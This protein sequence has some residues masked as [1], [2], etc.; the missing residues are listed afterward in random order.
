VILALLDEAQRSGARLGPACET[1]GINKRTVERWRGQGV[2]DDRR[3]GPTSAPPNKLTQQE[4][5]QIVTT[6]NSPEYRDLSPN[7]IVPLLADKGHYLSSESSFYRILREEDLQHHRE[8]SRPAV[9]TRPSAKVATG[10][11]QVWSWDITYLPSPVRGQFFYL[12][13]VMDVWSRK[14][15]GWEVHPIEDMALS[16][17]MIRRLCEENDITPDQLKLH[18]DNGGP[19]KGATMLAT[20]QKLGVATSF[21]R[22]RV[23]DDNP[24][25]EALFRTLKYRP[26]YPKRPFESIEEAIAWVAGFV[27]WYNEEHLHSEISFVTP[28][29]RHAGRDAEILKNR[30]EVYEQARK[31]N[32]SRW[33]GKTRN[34]TA[35]IKVVLNGNLQQPMDAAA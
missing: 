13:L 3:E 22:P 18:A 9:H 34:W 35:P 24:Y 14:I 31:K 16:S 27:R 29:D 21:S 26:E 23:S 12:Y 2:G 32:P 20:L 19:M 1:L 25:S 4:R 5:Q 11:N 15:V 7:Q 10:S 30:T 17:S 33:S 8:P 28:S 6:L